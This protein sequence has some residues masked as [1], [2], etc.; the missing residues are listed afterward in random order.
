[1]TLQ[2]LVQLR[3]DEEDSDFDSDNESSCSV[4]EGRKRHKRGRFSKIIQKM[5][6]S[7]KAKSS[8]GDGPKPVNSTPGTQGPT[9]EHVP[10]HTY[11]TPS[12]SVEKLRTLQ[13]YHGG[14]NQE[15]MAFM[16]A[17]SALTK[18]RLAV[19]AEQ[20]SIFLTAGK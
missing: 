1:L 15:R 6:L 4:A 7:T 8:S 20:V 13:S 14:L 16:E 5:F 11:G 18:K 12:V 9:N 3:P 17:H 2:K 10:T 19:S